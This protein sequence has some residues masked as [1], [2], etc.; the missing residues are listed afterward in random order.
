MEGASVFEGVVLA[1]GRSRRAGVFKPAIVHRGKSLLM[2]AVDGLAPWCE[3]IV[4]VAGHRHAQVT[5]LITGR[6]D[7]TMVVNPEPDDGMVSSVQVGVHAVDPSCEG[8]F[9]LP[10]DCPLAGDAVPGE[11]I[12]A[13]FDHGGTRVVVP[14]YE[15]RGGHPVLLPGSARPTI[16]GSPCETTLRLVIASIGVVRH[17]V[18]QPAVLMDIDTR[19]DVRALRR[20]EE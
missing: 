15:G 9:V 17:P 18:A 8:L 7:I 2:H 1:A 20:I 11:L 5:S 10:A 19:E 4:V 16:L 3:R 6:D 13:F 12:A 14:E